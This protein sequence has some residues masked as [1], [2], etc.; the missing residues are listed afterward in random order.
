LPVAVS[1]STGAVPTYAAYKF[2]IT[3]A[4]S[5]GITNVWVTIS[6]SVQP[7]GAATFLKS[8]LPRTDPAVEPCVANAAKT[9]ISCP[10]GSIDPGA[11]KTFVA[12]FNVPTQGT[13]IS[14]NWEIP[15]GQGGPNPVPSSNVVFT[16]NLVVTPM[17]AAATGVLKKGTDSSVQSY[18]LGDET[19]ATGVVDVSGAKTA[20]KVPVPAPVSIEQFIPPESCSPIYKTC[21]N[22]RLTIEEG[23]QQ[24]LFSPPYLQIELHRSTAT[25]KGGASINQAVLQYK[26]TG[27]WEDIPA[28]D[29]SGPVITIPSGN[30]NC[31][32]VQPGGQ[33]GLVDSVAKEWVFF[34]LGNKNGLRAF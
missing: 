7:S 16:G 6:T 19:L 28:C 4:Q 21:F 11:T 9:T 5:S 25:L 12:I 8:T 15:A 33:K 23:A 29:T 10:I 17:S 1:Y 22:S 32:V 18:V 3:N 2:P 30:V 13:Q 34:L 14:M 26:D 24:V 27:A 31:Y 20:V